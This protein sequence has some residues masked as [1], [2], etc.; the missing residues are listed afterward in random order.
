[1]GKGNIV[2]APS[3]GEVSATF[4]MGEKRL[5]IKVKQAFLNRVKREL[6]GRPMK[7]VIDYAFGI[8]DTAPDEIFEVA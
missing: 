1:M 8:M 2:I 5:K 3:P 6:D 4:R 7:A